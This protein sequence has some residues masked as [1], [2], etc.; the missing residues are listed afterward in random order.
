MIRYLTG[1]VI[2]RGEDFVVVEVNGVGYQVF[3]SAPQKLKG[4]VTLWVHHYVRED[5]QT[6]YGFQSQEE[7]ALFELLI[8]VSGVGPRAALAILKAGKQEEVI[9]AISQGNSAYFQAVP[10]IG[11]KV[12][13]KIVVELKS[14]ISGGKLLPLA[15][16]EQDETVVQAL[17]SLGYRRAEIVRIL[18]KLP[19]NLSPQEKIRWCLRQLSK[20]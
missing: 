18:P 3:V 6:L 17:R 8:T 19:Q 2:Y 4:K 10:G 15:L 1:K 7:L 12:A 11:A 16:S 9:T 5:Q 20:K 14:K 13:A